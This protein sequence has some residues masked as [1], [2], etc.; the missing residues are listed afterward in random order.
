MSA[1]PAT[2]GKQITFANQ[3]QD[4]EK[5]ARRSDDA[6]VVASSVTEERLHFAT[7]T[8]RIAGRATGWSS[9]FA[10]FWSSQAQ[11]FDFGAAAEGIGP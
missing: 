1:S 8:S 5:P 7:R 10:R 3:R 2:E 6:R 9:R 11:V 4:E